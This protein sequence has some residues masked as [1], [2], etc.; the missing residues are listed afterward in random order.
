MSTIASPRDPPRRT[1]TNSNRPS[2]E[3]SRS[4]L[5]SPVLTQGPTQ[6]PG[7]P[8]QQQRKTSNRAALREY[9]NLRASAPRIEIPD[10]EVPATEIDAPDFNVDEYVAKVVEKSSLEELLRLYTRVVGEVRALDAEKKAL[11]YDNYSKLI[12]ATETIRKMRANMDPLNPMASTLDPAIAQIYSQASSI[13]DALRETVPSPDSEEGKK[14]DAATRQQRTRELAAQVLATPE[15]LR[16]LVSEGKISQ[17]RKEWVMPRKLL[18]SWKEKGLGGSDVEECIE[19][20]DEALRPVDNK[21]SS[22]SPRISRDERPSRDERRS[23][24]SPQLDF[25]AHLLQG[26]FLFNSSPKMAGNG[27][28]GAWQVES[29]TFTKAVVAAMQKLYPEE[30]ADKSWDNVGLLVGNSENDAKTTNKVL[31]TNDLTYQV[32][33]DAIEQD[34][35]VIVSYHPFIFGGL[36][37]ITNK[38]PQQATLLRLAKAGI[39][40]YCPHTAVDA[41]PE[42]LNTWLADIVSG[43]HQSQ[44]SVAIPCSSAPSSHSGAGYGAIGRFEG[45]V[46]LSEIILRL[47]E[48][49]GGLKHVMVASPV[50]ADVKTTKISSFGVCAGSGYDVL[51]KAEVDLLV[52]GETSHH[53]ALR[54][55]QQGQTLVQVFHSNSERGYLQEVL[56]LKLEAAMKENV[57]EVEVVVSKYDKDPFTILD[58]NDLK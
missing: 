52:T 25:L 42:G 5:A 32:A 57:P 55:I 45:D 28:W 17:A 6:P 29:S 34:V 31:V 12:T 14:R 19:E 7:P 43:P 3:T 53:S 26:L 4:A 23:R 16:A 22:S 1:P 51:K 13:R 49:L 56:R 18:E 2:F 9:Y 50:G 30:I 40:V 36:K 15:R 24:D 46:S 10:S 27:A 58:V 20:G 37:S 47:A 21:S 41:A 35:S 8:Q 33:V 11:V 54:A 38:D 44:R 39:A 48:K